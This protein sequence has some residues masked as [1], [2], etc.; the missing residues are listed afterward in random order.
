MAGFIECSYCMTVSKYEDVHLDEEL[1]QRITS[2]ACYSCH[3]KRGKKTVWD[4]RINRNKDIDYFELFAIV[5][6]KKEG[7]KLLF[8][9]AWAGFPKQACSYQPEDNFNGALGI[10]QDY[11]LVNK[12]TTN[13]TP[14]GIGASTSVSEE[15][16]I[17]IK[18]AVECVNWWRSIKKGYNRDSTIVTSLEKMTS[19]SLA[20]IEDSGHGYILR[21]SPEYRKIIVADG[22]NNIIAEKGLQEYFSKL[23]KVDS[24]EL[25]TFNG[26]ISVDDCASSAVIIAL[27]FL[28]KT[29]EKRAPLTIHARVGLTRKHTS[30]ANWRKAKSEGLNGRKYINC[31]RE[32]K[33]SNQCEACGKK[34]IGRSFM[35][36]LKLHERQAHG[37]RDVVSSPAPSPV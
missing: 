19:D 18:Q 25:A 2:Y 28:K 5:G 27:E 26:Q 34:F 29:N 31:L 3:N 33:P 10:L 15:N 12:L 8:Q 36:A 6:H 37:G 22:T 32:L 30:M 35:K 20:I 11:C 16:F 21:K 1:A 7:D 23:L 4:G 14:R 13:V 17:Q 9:A 24:L